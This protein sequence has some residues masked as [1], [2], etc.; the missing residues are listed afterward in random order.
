VAERLGS[1][2][3]GFSYRVIWQ[4]DIKM[5]VVEL[6]ESMNYGKMSGLSGPSEE[7]KGW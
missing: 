6:M 4:P 5:G 1:Q 3:V 7:S 2:F